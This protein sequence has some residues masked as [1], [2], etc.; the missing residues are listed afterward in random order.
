[1]WLCR[2]KEKY[3]LD[4]LLSQVYCQGKPFPPGKGEFP[5][6]KETHTLMDYII[7]LLRLGEGF[8]G[9]MPDE[10]RGREFQGQPPSQEENGIRFDLP[11]PGKEIE[12]PFTA[13]KQRGFLFA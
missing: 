11:F 7:T 5:V 1:M 3:L 4:I 6:R 12:I 8:Q 2:T 9:K 13:E 10:R